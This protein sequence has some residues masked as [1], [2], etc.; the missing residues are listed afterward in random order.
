MFN[1]ISK[2]GYKVVITGN[3]AD[4]LL[5]DMM[6]NKTIL[7]NILNSLL[8]KFF[9]NKANQNVISKASII[10][11]NYSL[12]SKFFNIELNDSYLYEESKYWQSCLIQKI[13]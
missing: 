4:E 7:T 8:K 5:W 3:G 6:M 12:N 11:K 9:E 1:Q 2:D 13:I 10:N